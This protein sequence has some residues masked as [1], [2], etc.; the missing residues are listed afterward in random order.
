VNRLDELNS[1][2]QE[3]LR[4]Y[5]DKNFLSAAKTSDKIIS[6]YRRTRNTKSKEYADDL[7]NAGVTQH[8]LGNYK[9]AISLYA[10]SARVVSERYG[11]CLIKACRITNLAIIHNKIG[12]DETALKLHMHTKEI[13]EN[14]KEIESDEYYMCLYNLGNTYFNLEMYEEAV[15]FLEKPFDIMRERNNIDAIDVGN[16]LG[17]A[18]EENSNYEM[19]IEVF[20]V[21]IG[22]L[23][24]HYSS[25]I[26]EILRNIYYLADV[27]SRAELFEKS[28]AYFEESLELMEKLIPNKHS[29]YTNCLNSLADT[30]FALGE[31][32]NAL[33]KR[34]NALSALKESIG[35]N[36]L[37][38]SNCLK[39]ISDIY[40]ELK[41][42]ENAEKYLISQIDIKK[43]LL[44]SNCKAYIPDL[45]SLLEVYAESDQIDKAVDTLTDTIDSLNFEDK[46]SDEFLY[47][48]VKIY[49]SLGGIKLLNE[50]LV[51]V[52]D[53][54]TDDGIKKFFNN[55]IDGLS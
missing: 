5:M 29:L 28:S 50:V 36:H 32:E 47:E 35:E 31:Y 40:R 23:K 7:F 18:Y 45:L 10:E 54:S 24:N 38:Y 12:D 17:Y 51:R 30:Y 37:H 21:V 26:W 52:A 9:K 33:E 55:I 13:L 19:A 27:C 6:H 16:S 3:F 2:R 22:I 34:L 15:E 20:E 46:G 25:D 14:F 4:Y 39:D 1:L 49:W 8:E 11:D 53:L 42:Y 41:D 44:G 48:L 43:K